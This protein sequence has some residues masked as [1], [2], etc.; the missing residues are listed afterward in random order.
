[1]KYSETTAWAPTRD[2]LEQQQSLHWLLLCKMFWMK[3]DKLGHI[4]NPWSERRSK[5]QPQDTDTAE[6]KVYKAHP[7]F[8][9][10][11]TTMVYDSLTEGVLYNTDWIQYTHESGHVN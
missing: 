9:S 2:K 3:S 11:W 7:K 1:M 4:K 6:T 8:L 10:S 5:S